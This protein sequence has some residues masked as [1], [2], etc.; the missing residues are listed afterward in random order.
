MRK[1][2]ISPL[3]WILLSIN[4]LLF[5][6]IIARLIGVFGVSATTV[7]MGLQTLFAG[8]LLWVIVRQTGIIKKQTSISEKMATFNEKVDAYERYRH[9]L[10]LYHRACEERERIFSRLETLMQQI[11]E[12]TSQAGGGHY[13]KVILAHTAQ[14]DRLEKR[15]K[16]DASISDGT[17]TAYLHD[18][19]TARGEAAI[20]EELTRA[21]AVET[22]TEE[23][24]KIMERIEKARR[25]VLDLERQR[26]KKAS[27]ESPQEDE[28]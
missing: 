15:L 6:Y 26:K 5:V 13:D 14:L 18:A 27:E 16:E 10:S 21:E 24:N 22:S 25:N 1:L 19:A 3:G 4:G 17:I 28:S 8:L 9:S 7:F 23:V 12:K 11:W 2:N 20:F